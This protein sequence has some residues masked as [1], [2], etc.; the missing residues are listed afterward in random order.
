MVRPKSIRYFELCYLGCVLVGGINTAMTW[1]SAMA[2][3][4]G[5]QAR[6]VVGPWFLPIAFVFAYTLAL[7]LWYFTARVPSRVAKWIVILWFGLSVLTVGFNLI[8]GPTF[9]TSTILSVVTLLLN[10]AA[11]W[12]LLR[13]DSNSWFAKA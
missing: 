6:A 2:S 11:V 13:P 3:D 10:A 7:L 8:K 1:A 4:D 9:E 5:Q 12:F